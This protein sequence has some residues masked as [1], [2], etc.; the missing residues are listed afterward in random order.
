MGNIG[1]PCYEDLPHVDTFYYM[2][3]KIIVTNDAF[4]VIRKV[5]TTGNFQARRDGYTFTCVSKIQKVE[6]SHW[7]QILLVV[8]FEA[9]SV[10]WK[11]L[12]DIQ[13]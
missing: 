11:C 12:P 3:S 9:H 10:L 7:Q 4:H 6:F 13:A 5:I 8:F 2:V 1:S